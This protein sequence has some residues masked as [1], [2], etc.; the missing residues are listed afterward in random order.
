M[1]FKPIIN[2]PPRLIGERI[3]RD[4]PMGLKLREKPADLQTA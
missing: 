2:E 3:F 4:Q 1:D